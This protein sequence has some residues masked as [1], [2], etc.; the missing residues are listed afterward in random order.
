MKSKTEWYRLPKEE[1]FELLDSCDTGLTSSEA[2]TRLKSYGYNE[3]KIK[4][5][6]PLIR[7]L[8]QFHNPLVYVLLAASVLTSILEI[9]TD[10]AVI[11]GVVVLNVIIGFIDIDK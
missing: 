9:W 10:T 7:F 1:I 6:G 4:K 2:M 3:L 11:L 8:L 5:Q